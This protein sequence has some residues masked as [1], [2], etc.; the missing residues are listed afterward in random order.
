MVQA[1][2]PIKIL[3]IF[4]RMVRDGAETRTLEIMRNIDRTK[5]Q[6]HFCSLSGLPGDLDDEIR[7]LGGQVH[8][9]RLALDFP[10]R[11]QRLLR[12]HQFDVVHSHVHYFSGYILR[13]AARA[14]IPTRI[15]HFRITEDGQGNS[16]RRRCQRRLMRYWIDQYATCILAV[17]QA[18]MDA[19]WGPQ[20]KSDRR[21][22][23]I[24]NGL[25][26]SA[27]EEPPDRIGVRQEFNLPSTCNLYIH[28]GRMDPQKNHQRVLSIFA[29]LLLHDPQA[30]LL[31]VGR[32][33][34]AIVRRLRLHA[35]ALNISER[36]IIAGKRSDVPRLLQ[37]ADLLLFPSLW[38]GL[39]GVVLEAGAA[40]TPV[41]ASNLPGINEIA[42][43]L[44]LVRCLPL[45][46][47]DNVWAQAAAHFNI[48]DQ[49]PAARADAIQSFASSV[50]NINE[51]T[52][53]HCLVWQS[54]HQLW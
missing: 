54:Q 52:K 27:F 13:L 5:Y 18:A 43:Q 6:L 34:N 31:L 1:E 14:A 11:F 24:Y 16:L 33:D 22:Q 40:G 48:Q 51:C 30:Y 39:P 20:W 12:E 44:P 37:A 42:A 46:T 38:E 47:D 25:D 29:Q 8:L 2:H 41:I 21:C 10:W 45:D 15:A 36:L 7:A 50:F 19:S 32:G 49:P 26:L 35:K 17:C 23:V 9:C 3:H 53:A 4:G 28:V